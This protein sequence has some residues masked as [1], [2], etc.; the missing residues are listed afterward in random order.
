[1]GY[2]GIHLNFQIKLEGVTNL[3][4]FA[5]C[6]I[7]SIIINVA[8]VSMVIFCQT[9]YTIYNIPLFYITRWILFV[10]DIRLLLERRSAKYDCYNIDEGE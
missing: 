5:I 4:F 1:M 6:T 2:S 10:K 3:S 7:L 9:R 8:V